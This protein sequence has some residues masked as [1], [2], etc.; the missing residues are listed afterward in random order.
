MQRE[1][2]TPVERWVVGLHAVEPPGQCRSLPS[3]NL[4]LAQQVVGAA[5]ADPVG[6]LARRMPPQLDPFR[7]HPQWLAPDQPG[8]E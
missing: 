3:G 1:G 4:H 5:L 2:A 8:L 6:E 7:H